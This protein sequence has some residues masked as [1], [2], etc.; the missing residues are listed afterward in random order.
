MNQ[1]PVVSNQYRRQKTIAAFIALVAVL[2]TV[3]SIWYVNRSA[4][5]MGP[6]KEPTKAELVSQGKAMGYKIF[7]TEELLERFQK[8]PG[9]LL[10]VDTR[11]EW[12]YKTEHIVGAVVFPTDITWWWRLRNASAMG[13]ILGPDK[14]RTIVFY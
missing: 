8:D 2:L 1:D 3:G 6:P 11:Q 9:S 12:E 13:K 7:T 4:A 5:P 14:D 10:V